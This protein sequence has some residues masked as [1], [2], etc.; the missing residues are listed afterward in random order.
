MPNYI[1][2]RSAGALIGTSFSVYFRHFGTIL[3]I[4][5]VLAAPLAVITSFLQVLEPQ[6]YEVAIIFVVS[7]LVVVF[8]SYLASAVLTVTISDILKEK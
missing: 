6:G 4:Y 7:A 2:A 1:G 3:S 8:V 5:I